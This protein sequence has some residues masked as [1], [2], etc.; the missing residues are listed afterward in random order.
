MIKKIK[1]KKIINKVPKYLFKNRST[2]TSFGVQLAFL[3]LLNSW[4]FK[5][6][7]IYN[8]DQNQFDL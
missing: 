1:P 2:K 7:E 8:N 5:N 4:D 6:E 3:D